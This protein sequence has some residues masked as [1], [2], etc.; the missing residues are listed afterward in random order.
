MQLQGENNLSFFSDKI[1]PDLPKF[2][3]DIICIWHSIARVKDDRTP[4]KAIK[5]GLDEKDEHQAIEESPHISEYAIQV[6]P[7]TSNPEEWLDERAA[8]VLH[9]KGYSLENEIGSGAFSRI[10]LA[11]KTFKDDGLEIW[12]AI[13]IMD[14]IRCKPV[15]RQRFVP[16]E[17]QTLKAFEHPFAVKIFDIFRMSHKIWI[18]MEY[19]AGGTL[20]AFC[21]RFDVGLPEPL[22]GY[23]FNQILSA[24]D[25]LHSI[26]VAHR[27][28]KLANVLLDRN[29]DCKLS[30]YGFAR[31]VINKESAVKTI[32]GTINMFSPELLKQEP[33][34]PFHADAWALGVMLFA[35]IF[36][37][38]P[39]PYTK[40]A[41][42]VLE[43]FITDQERQA[44]HETEGWAGASVQVQGLIDGLLN[45][46]PKKRLFVKDARKHQ[47]SIVHHDR[48]QM[49]D[50]I[51]IHDPNEETDAA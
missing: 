30:D 23:W 31:P 16:R 40:R 39:F 8:M 9:H 26:Q 32:C 35:M 38:W 51:K 37:R 34:N 20:H 41:P 6:P 2:G 48:P 19:C 44:Y 18:A 1:R 28:L 50:E 14:L 17:I 4:G 29:K 43:R 15:F 13:K 24:V 3:D 49:L 10:Y 36:R 45:P 47:W 12:A 33:Y 42:E 46:D 27:D 5:E 21:R 25:A 11:R 22:V 7:L